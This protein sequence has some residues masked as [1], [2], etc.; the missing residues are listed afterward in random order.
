MCV[1]VA[2]SGT[3][4][5][6]WICSPD[7]S[8]GPALALHRDT[9]ICELATPRDPDVAPG[10]ADR[11]CSRGSPGSSSCAAEPHLSNSLNHKMFLDYLW[12]IMSF[13]RWTL[14]D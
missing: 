1:L 8:Q 5:P 13:A 12:V 2:A 9:H 6:G 3:F 11:R 7:A 14:F 4:L 10:N